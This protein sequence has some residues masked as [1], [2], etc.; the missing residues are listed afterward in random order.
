MKPPLVLKAGHAL[1]PF[2]DVERIM[3]SNV[4]RDVV[5]IVTYSGKSYRAV[6]FDALEAVLAVKPSA[7]EGRR[8]KWRHSGWT[9]HNVVGHP[10]M[11]LLAWTGFK[12]AAIRLH[13]ATTPRR[14]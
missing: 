1:I 2:R 4:E 5:E 6:G 11:Q 14:R 7:I 10:L 8:I 12:R 13:D 3:I 9:F